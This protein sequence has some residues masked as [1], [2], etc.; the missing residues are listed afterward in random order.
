MALGTVP[1]IPVVKSD[2]VMEVGKYIDFHVTNAN[3]SDN[4]VRLTASSSALTCNKNITA[5]NVTSNN[6][7]R[8]TTVESKLSP[9]QYCKDVI[10]GVNNHT[11]EV[12][13]DSLTIMMETYEPVSRFDTVIVNPNESKFWRALNTYTTTMMD[14]GGT[15]V[16][17]YEITISNISSINLEGP[18]TWTLKINDGGFGV[19]LDIEHHYY[20][21]VS[22]D[23]KFLTQSM[24]LNMIYPIGSIYTS[25]RNVNPTNIFGGTWS[26]IIDR[27]MYCV[28][29]TNGTSKQTGGSKKITVN[30]LPAHNHTINFQGWYGC[31]SGSSKNCIA[32]TKITSDSVETG[33]LSSSNTGSGTDYMPPYITVYAWERTA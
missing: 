2:G 23:D 15:P 5:P 31:E 29:P 14:E 13:N 22:N 11:Y 26:A 8:L 27:F 19:S 17:H 12:I 32:R 30:N 21:N 7:T 10:V 20:R 3:S 24:L 28:D 33:P 18:D 16:Y 9:S 6:N 4:D 25:T 1:V